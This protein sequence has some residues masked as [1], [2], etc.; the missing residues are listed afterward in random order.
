MEEYEPRH[1]RPSEESESRPLVPLPV[2]RWL[3]GVTTALVPLFVAY[4][5]IDE[6]T[7][8]LWIALAV[9]VFATAT[10]FVNT[11]APERGR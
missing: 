2:R 6:A 8:P 4:G 3:Y 1:A 9:Q 10:A 5:I 11:P 7:A